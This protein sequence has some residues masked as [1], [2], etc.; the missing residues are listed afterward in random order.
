VLYCII[1]KIILYVVDLRLCQVMRMLYLFFYFQNSN[2]DYYVLIH[3]V[4]IPVGQGFVTIS[5][6]TEIRHG[7]CLDC[8]IFVI[9]AHFSSQ[10]I[11]WTGQSICQFY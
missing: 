7:V 3:V 11:G 4:T 2:G 5:C 1:L 9:Q 6:N 8:A 10:H